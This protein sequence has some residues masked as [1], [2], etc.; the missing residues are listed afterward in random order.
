MTSGDFFQEFY[1]RSSTATQVQ[2]KYIAVRTKENKL[3]VQDKTAM[4]VD[5]Y[6]YQ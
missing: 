6:L 5:L 4:L 1:T 2:L 3:A